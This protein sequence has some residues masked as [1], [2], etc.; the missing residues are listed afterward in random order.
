MDVFP[1]KAIEIAR[2]NPPVLNRLA[3]IFHFLGKQE[4][5]MA[6]CNMALDARPDPA[7][8]WQAYSMRAKVCSILSKQCSPGIPM[9]LKKPVFSLVKLKRSRFFLV[10]LCFLEV[11]YSQVLLCQYQLYWLLSSHGSTSPAV[12]VCNVTY[13]QIHIVLMRAIFGVPVLVGLLRKTQ[14]K[15]LK[16]KKL[17]S[18]YTCF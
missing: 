8:N 18:K 4:M 10:A 2:D 14:N 11:P 7:L 5:A 1:L 16:A 6:V 15:T 12:A 13:T 9:L 17:M 3:K